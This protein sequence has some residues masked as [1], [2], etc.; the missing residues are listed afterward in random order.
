MPSMLGSS[1]GITMTG[2]GATGTN[3]SRGSSVQTWG[4]T[5]SLWGWR[6]PGIGCPG[7]LWSLLL[8]RYSRPAWT[9]S[10]AACSGWPTE[11]PSNPYHSVI[12]W[13]SKNKNFHLE[14]YRDIAT[15]SCLYPWQKEGYEF[16]CQLPPW[17]SNPFLSLPFTPEKLKE[18]HDFFWMLHWPFLPYWESCSQKG[19]W[20]NGLKWIR[21]FCIPSRGPRRRK[22]TSE[23]KRRYFIKLSAG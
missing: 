13:L 4:R 1:S 20:I 5:S 10:C 11:D 9:R 22:G 17:I 21:Y 19:W 8:W 15:L 12:L 6:S 16:I 18:A 7:R 3:W 14:V 2:Q 23:N